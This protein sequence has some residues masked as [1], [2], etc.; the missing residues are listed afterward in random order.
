MDWAAI[1][2][3]A[4]NPLRNKGLAVQIQQTISG[5]LNDDTGKIT[6]ATQTFNGW[7]VIVKH[8]LTEKNNDVVKIGD[9]QVVVAA[10][11]LGCTPQVGDTLIAATVT[12][13]IVLVEP[14]EPAGVPILFNCYVRE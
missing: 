8:K 11:N 10:K 9:K 3:K 7:G 14:V 2:T 4:Y 13:R 6:Q 12:G 5:N 1:Q